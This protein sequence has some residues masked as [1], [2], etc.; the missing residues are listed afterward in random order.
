MPVEMIDVKIADEQELKA[1]QY[2]DPTYLAT[3]SSTKD[4]VV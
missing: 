4:T 2:D 1:T 3:M